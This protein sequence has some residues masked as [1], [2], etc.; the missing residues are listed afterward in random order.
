[1]STRAGKWLLPTETE[2]LRAWKKAL[3]G[4]KKLLHGRKKLLHDGNRLL[5]AERRAPWGGQAS[6]YSL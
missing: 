2:L 5:R 6:D 3:H 1:M 4:R